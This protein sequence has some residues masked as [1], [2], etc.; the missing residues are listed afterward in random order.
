MH[1]T[2]GADRESYTEELFNTP[3]LFHQEWNYEVLS[4][5]NFIPIQAILFK[6]CLYEQRGGFDVEL[7]QLEDWNL[8]LRFGFGN[9]FSYVPKTTSLFRSPADFSV[10]AARHE[11]LHLAYIEAKGRAKSSLEGLGLN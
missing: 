2:V 6:R 3:S 1:T 8:W 10:R 5:H 11:L 4:D 9:R 7:D